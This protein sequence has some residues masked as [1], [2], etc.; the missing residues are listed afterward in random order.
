MIHNTE[1]FEMIEDYCLGLLSDELKSEF[2]AELKQNPKLSEEL[3]LQLE[4]QKSIVELDVLNLR[5]KI[6]K[7]AKQNTSESIGDTPFELFNDFSE[8]QEINEVLSTE[9]LINFYDSLPRAHAY[10][11]ESTSN[12]NIHQF[13]RD[14][15]NEAGINGFE[16]EI[17][18]L[19]F[20]LEFEGLEEAILEKDVL[21]LRQTLK[22][23]AKSVEPQYSV[24]EIDDFVNG[25]LSGEQLL[26]FEKELSKNRS[27][28]EEVLLHSNV[29]N[30]VQES[31]IMNL[32]NQISNITQSETSWTVSE[33]SIEDYIDGLLE[34]ED[35]E[36]FSK[37]LHD[38]LDLKAEVN[39]R[40]QVNE[41]LAESD[42]EDLRAQLGKAKDTAEVKTVKMFIPETKVS[43]I[44]FW[45]TSVAVIVILLGMAGVLRNGIVNSS[46][47]DV[48]TK[49]YNSPVWSTERSA[50]E[51]LDI[52]QKAQNQFVN[53][54]WQN[55]INS[56]ENSPDDIRL[57]P[58]S[59]FFE[60]ASFQNLE[61]FSDA[62]AKYT[63][64]IENGDNV[65][66][67][68]AEWNRALCYY[69]TKNY[70]KATEQLL[71]VMER[72]GSYHDEARAI[73]KRL[74]YSFK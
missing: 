69:R 43:H 62:I 18:D 72:K 60:G 53:A 22:Q 74:K 2:E 41:L 47:I 39:L 32:R 45:R 34:G 68:E 64:V 37:E 49:S 61:K 51:H 33:E 21:N 23:V 40:R 25:E 56:L 15:Q 57:G 5:N 28:R 29:D 26:E 31:D 67:E 55:T 36:E 35:L 70:K 19:D 50:T 8:I 46:N 4:I 48:Y 66:I 44:G 65:F 54:H 13:Y 30:A 27:F 20:N 10:H 14:Q 6:Q 12:E 52:L 58:V 24:E 59:Q 1:F 3:E 38:N 11:H 42:I 9:E 73:L 63:N 7:V 71:A 16:E 17:D